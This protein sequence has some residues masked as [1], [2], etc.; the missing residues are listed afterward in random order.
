M[1]SQAFVGKAA[2]GPES[3]G[4]GGVGRPRAVRPRVAQVQAAVDEESAGV[5]RTGEGEAEEGDQHPV[6]AHPEDGLGVVAVPRVAP[7]DAKEAPGLVAV[8]IGHQDAHA[9]LL[10]S[11]ARQVL[12]PDDAE[13]QRAGVVHD[14]HVGDLPVAVVTLQ[15][16][17]DA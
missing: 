12:L 2:P 5:E 13:K 3:R 11:D 14:G 7:V 6:L 9:R 15:V 16:V 1:L 8:L 4:V 10:G 17:D